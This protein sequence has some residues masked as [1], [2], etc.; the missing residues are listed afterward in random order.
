MW[1]W[2][3]S[4]NLRHRGSRGVV[5]RR[6]ASRRIVGR[7]RA[8]LDLQRSHLA[9]EETASS[10]LRNGGSRRILCC[11]ATSSISWG[12]FWLSVALLQRCW[13]VGILREFGA[14]GFRF[15]CWERIMPF[16]LHSKGR[17]H[18]PRQ[19]HRV[20]NWRVGGLRSDRRPFRS[21]LSGARTPENCLNRHVLH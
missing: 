15:S 12:F 18:I 19:R 17:R 7:A 9:T 16:K 11:A 8:F 5:G 3:Q 14:K 10:G 21:G 13:R 20:T 2:R 6:S 1:S 4:A